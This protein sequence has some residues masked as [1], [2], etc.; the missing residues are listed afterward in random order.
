MIGTNHGKSGASSEI[1][2][3]PACPF[4]A[5]DLYKHFRARL[6][7][8]S[9]EELTFRRLGQIIGKSK[10]TAHFW[11]GVSTQPQ[12]IAWLCLLERLSSKGR[13]EFIETHCRI[14]P[15]LEHPFLAHAPGKT[16]KLLELLSQ[17][18]G[19]T[20]ICGGTE[21]MRTFVVTA[22]GHAYRQATGLPRNAVG[23]DVHRPTRIVPI[24]SLYYVD[25]TQN[26]KQVKQ[27]I[28]QLWPRIQ[29]S[30][31]KLVVCNGIWSRVPDLRKEILRCSRHNHV[32]LAESG[33]P[34]IDDVRTVI[35]G[36]LHVVAVSAA[37]RISG[38]INIQCRQLKTRKR[39][40][41]AKSL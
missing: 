26:S 9:G 17:R 31:G 40:K 15:S 33:T 14:L 38:G 8:E 28:F 24:E 16:G 6:A 4:S 5:Q 23:L 11:F 19:L 41:K 36:P 34:V 7:G 25:G 2:K 27:L 3:P 21:T 35:T 18:T 22:L 32:L 12:V 39:P 10:S 13:H 1:I 37:K 20:V 30:S 29:A